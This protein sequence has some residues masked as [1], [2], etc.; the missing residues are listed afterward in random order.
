[1]DL[2]PTLLPTLRSAVTDPRHTAGLD[3]KWYAYQHAR[4]ALLANFHALER[5]CWDYFDDPERA[6]K[7]FRMWLGG[8]TT[9]E[10]AR[11]APSGRPD[12]YRPEPR[13]LTFTMTWLIQQGTPAD[14]ALRDLCDIAEPELW[15]RWVFAHILR[16]MGV[17]SFASVVSDVM[18][19]IPRDD[20]WGLTAQDLTDP[21][22]HYLRVIQP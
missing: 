15:R 1:M 10:G 9:E 5:G 13:Y 18:Y 12:P 8:M 16:G 7:D 14:R 4:E 19:L 20:D 21:K 2:A 22:F 6:E 3:A 17:V 11:S